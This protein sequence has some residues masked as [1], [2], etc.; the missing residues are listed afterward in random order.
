MRGQ[1]E[2]SKEAF[3]KEALPTISTPDFPHSQAKIHI[4]GLIY[5]SF[6]IMHKSDV[7]K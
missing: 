7:L 1:I 6:F 4:L 3:S 5:I 2:E